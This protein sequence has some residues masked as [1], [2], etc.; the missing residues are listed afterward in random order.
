RSAAC[1]PRPRRMRTALSLTPDLLS[2]LGHADARGSIMRRIVPS[3]VLIKTAGRGF[4][5]DLRYANW[6]LPHVPAGDTAAVFMA[7]EVRGGEPGEPASDVYTVTA[8]I[9]A[10]LT[11]HEPNPDPTQLVPPRQLRPAIPAAVERVI[12]RGL[13]H[14]PKDRYFT[15]TEML[16]DFVSDAGTFHTPAA[17]PELTESGFERRLRRALGD[18]YELLEE[19]GTRS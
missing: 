15:A 13:S 4:I 2:A 11:G 12:L 1:G 5:T 18:D 8:N 3:T 14:V 6:C 17:A 16:E 7:L 9:Y 10:A 19:I